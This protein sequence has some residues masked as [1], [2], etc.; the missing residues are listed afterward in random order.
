MTTTAELQH[1]A[2]GELGVWRDDGAI[3]IKTSNEHDDPVE[4]SDEEAVALADLLLRLA[5]A[6]SPASKPEE[7]RVG[8]GTRDRRAAPD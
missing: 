6:R 3:C 8:A 4:L 5:G 1:F 7:R 2:G